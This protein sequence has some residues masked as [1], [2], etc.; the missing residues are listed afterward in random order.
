MKRAR[1]WAAAWEQGR[2]LDTVA[3]E[4]DHQLPDTEH[5][6]TRVEARLALPPAIIGSLARMAATCQGR[7]RMAAYG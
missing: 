4:Y 6:S 3:A 1:G 2:A 5:A 7:Q